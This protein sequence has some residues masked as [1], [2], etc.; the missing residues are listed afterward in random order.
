LKVLKELAGAVAHERISDLSG[1]LQHIVSLKR[2]DCLQM[3]IV[4]IKNSA[5]KEHNMIKKILVVDDEYTIRESLRELFLNA[6]YECDGAENGEDALRLIN[7]CKYDL[8]LSDI[9]MPLM[10]GV[11][12][13]KKLCRG[14]I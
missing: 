9:M 7:S 6:G 10:S 1:N 5:H 11:E 12:L 13:F 3:E 2:K 8:I 14:I 4:D